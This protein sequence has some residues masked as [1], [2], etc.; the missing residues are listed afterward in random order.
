AMVCMSSPSRDR[1]KPLRLI[2]PPWTDDSPRRLEIDAALPADDPARRV[3]EVVAALDLARLVAS[4]AGVGSPA[5]PPE[6]LLRV[7]LFEILRG[8]L[9]PGRW[10]ADCSRDDALKWLTF[11]AAPSRS[12]LF[13]FRDR[14][15]PHLDALL[16]SALHTARARG[17]TTAG[18]IALDG[19]FTG[20][21][22]SRHKPMKAKGLDERCR[23]LDAAVTA[24]LAAAPADHS[25]P[26]S[27][28][29]SATAADHSPPQP[30]PAWMATTPGGRFR[31]RRLYHQARARLGDRQRA[32]DAQASRRS[33][34]QRRK[35]RPL[36]ASP[37][38]PEAVL[39]LDK[40]KVFRPL[41]D[42]QLARDLDSN[43][44][45]G[46][47]VF[48]AA[49]DVGLLAPMLDRTEALTGVTP[50]VVL[51]DGTYANVIEL[52]ACRERAVTLYAPPQGGEAATKA[53]GRSA[54]SEPGRK[55]TK[56]EFT[57]LAESKTYRCPAGHE[58]RLE[59]RGV[60]RR[61]GGREL[62]ELQY[63]CPG[64]LCR[65]CSLAARCTRSPQGRIIKRSEHDDLLEDL[66]R[67]MAS[68]EGR[69]LYKLRSRTIERE[70]ADL[71]CHRGLRQFSV[72]GLA[73]SRAQ[74]GLLILIHNGLE[75][76]KA[77][78]RTAEAPADGPQAA[79]PPP[80][81]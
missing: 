44:I 36:K 69:E 4:Y 50:E 62:V 5:Y 17:W 22:A 26:A 31:Q 12:C 43:F 53:D 27:P 20:S 68:P 19:T 77:L 64:E 80:A 74:V 28:L 47:E 67:R 39:G 71:K 40:T 57:W 45:L 11:G 35:A 63:R 25:P 7:V 30:P 6:I 13:R 56:A 59:R 16:A 48:A 23:Q 76:L 33:R 70:F 15:A 60:Q 46:Y 37:T 51:A 66:R 78:R 1:P 75:F 73:R 55:I 24:D 65:A 10:A 79:Q 21:Y 58:L 34:A 49:T 52:E 81:A 72:F 8:R 61:F 18:R 2:S 41:F 14:I 29:D 3:A 9:S 38:D 42:I 32:R 54:A